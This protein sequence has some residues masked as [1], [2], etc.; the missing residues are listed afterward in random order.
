MEAESQ[1][2]RPSF[3]QDGNVRELPP[4]ASGVAR[5]HSYGGGDPSLDPRAFCSYGGEGR[6]VPVRA[7]AFTRRHQTAEPQA[8]LPSSGRDGNLREPRVPAYL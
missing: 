8:K 3:P 7:V 5:W 6:A 2:A 4:T 1:A